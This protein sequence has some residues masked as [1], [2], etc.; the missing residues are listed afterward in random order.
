LKKLNHKLAQIEKIEVEVESP[1]IHKTLV[2]ARVY[3]NFFGNNV[4]ITYTTKS[5]RHREG[6]FRSDLLLIDFFAPARVSTCGR[7]VK[8]L[9]LKIPRDKIAQQQG[10]SITQSSNLPITHSFFP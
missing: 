9:F 1:Q 5:Y 3:P 7:E 4:E 8:K 6:T 10:R 2:I